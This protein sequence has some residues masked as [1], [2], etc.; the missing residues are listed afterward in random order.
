MLY[1][2]ADCPAK[3][4]AVKPIV[5]LALSTTL[6]ACQSVPVKRELP[7]ASFTGT[8]WMLVTERKVDG[9]QPFLEFGDGA[10]SGSTGCNRIMGRYVQDSL[11]A[12]AII[13]SSIASTKRMCADTLMAIE[14]KVLGVLRSSTNVKVTGDRL[15]IDGSAG[16]LDFIADK[17]APPPAKSS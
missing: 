13:F 16:A 4:F 1:S 3:E 10:V 7:P 11:G 2:V 14:E 6:F 8:K 9:E 5:M 15:R 12:G 17:P